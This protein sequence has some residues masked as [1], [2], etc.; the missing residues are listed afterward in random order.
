MKKLLV[1]MSVGVLVSCTNSS[2]TQS[3]TADSLNVIVDSATVN[4]DSTM[5]DTLGTPKMDS[6][7]VAH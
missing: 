6:V 4:S 7:T 3:V 2:D 1:I 5:V